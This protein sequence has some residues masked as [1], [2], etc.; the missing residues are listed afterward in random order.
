MVDRAIRVLIM[1]CGNDRIQNSLKVYIWSIKAH[2]WCMLEFGKLWLW[3]R[4]EYEWLNE[5]VCVSD[6]M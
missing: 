2:A 3:D 6:H 1:W 4:D 5:C